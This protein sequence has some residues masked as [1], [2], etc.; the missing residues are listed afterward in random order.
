MGIPDH[1]ARSTLLMLNDGLLLQPEDFIYRCGEAARIAGD[2]S[3]YA[4][5][6][7]VRALAHEVVRAASAFQRRTPLDKTQEQWLPT[8]AQNLPVQQQ[9][10]QLQG[11][12]RAGGFDFSSLDMADLLALRDAYDTLAVPLGPALARLI[13]AR[14]APCYEQAV[15][16]AARCLTASDAAGTQGALDA[17]ALLTVEIIQSLQEAGAPNLASAREQRS[18]ERLLLV[19]AIRR[20]PLDDLPALGA[21]LAAPQAAALPAHRQTILGMMHA[22]V[23]DRLAQMAHVAPTTMHVP[24][25][26]PEHG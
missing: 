4:D 15:N 14:L 1:A 24:A 19:S 18:Y 17:I 25:G 26:R 2:V 11:V 13:A 20:M 16:D 6:A 8:V 23:S 3:Q 21:A 10:A 22:A 9:H 7:D 12:L 5:P